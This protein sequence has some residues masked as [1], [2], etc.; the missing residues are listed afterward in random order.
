MEFAEDVFDGPVEGFGAFYGDGGVGLGGEDVHFRHGSGC[1]FELGYDGFFGAAAFAHIAIDAAVEANFVGGIDVDAEV[2]ERDELGVVEGEDAF[3]ED[4]AGG[5]DEVEGV[6]DAGVAGEVV[7]RALDGEAFGER[8]DVGDDELGLEGVGVVEVLFVAGVEREPREVA[9][10]VVE[11]E[12]RGFELR[13]VLFGE[14]GFAGAGTAGDADQE[15]V[16]G[17]G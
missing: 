16:V 13:G 15:W 5:V 1:G 12:E 17:E 11:G 3:D 9:V 4:D 14:S 10:V 6:G 7:Y 8:A 2:V